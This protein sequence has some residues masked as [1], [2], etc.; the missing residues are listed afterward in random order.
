MMKKSF[1]AANEYFFLIQLAL[2]IIGDTLS[3]E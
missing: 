2:I 1:R 3:L